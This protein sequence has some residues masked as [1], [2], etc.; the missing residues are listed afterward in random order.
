MMDI[1][2]NQDISKMTVGGTKKKKHRKKT[3]PTKKRRSTQ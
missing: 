2:D 3:S 1:I